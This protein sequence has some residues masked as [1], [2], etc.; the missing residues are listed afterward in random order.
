MSRCGHGK[1]YR[2][3]LEAAITELGGDGTACSYEP[4]SWV[5][6]TPFCKRVGVPRQTMIGR[7]SAWHAHHRSRGSRPWT[8]P[9]VCLIYR[10]GSPPG[11]PR[12]GRPPGCWLLDATREEEIWF[13]L[14]N[15]SSW[16]DAE[17]K[18]RRLSIS[19][20]APRPGVTEL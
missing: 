6:L 5:A 7:L 4:P 19:G 2:T 3:V 20:E 18:R 11:V 17:W 16:S 10:Q 14:R 8:A 13:G 15:F 1:T 9:L 12:R